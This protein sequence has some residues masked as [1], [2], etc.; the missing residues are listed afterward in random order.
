MRAGYRLTQFAARTLFRVL[1]GV[2]V[3]GL[4][5]IP[6]NG[7]VI[8]AANHRSNFD[9][10][11][12]GCFVRRETHFF[13]KVELFRNPLFAWLI[14]YLNAFPVRRGVFDKDSLTTCLRILKRGEA[15]VFFPEGTRAP[16]DGFL[17]AKLGVGWV[18]C[19]SGAPIIPIYLHGTSDRWLYVRNRPGMAVVVGKP[20]R[21]E[22]LCSGAARGKTAYQEVADRLLERIRDL[23]LETPNGRVTPKG[24]IYSR[25]II[26]E[27]HLR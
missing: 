14:R 17:E 15:L 18:A 13:A 19:L 27:E 7:P 9:P 4:E 6:S 2:A 21:V 20:I 12:V 3:K 11:L 5:N 26:E 16:R 24:P 1:S 25:D 22:E 8:L 10:P 23:S